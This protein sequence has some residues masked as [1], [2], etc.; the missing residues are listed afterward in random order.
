MTTETKPRC[1]DAVMKPYHETDTCAI[2]GHMCL[3]ESG[4]ECQIYE[5]FLAKCDAEADIVFHNSLK[6]GES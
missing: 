3:L 1:P 6:E 2:R 5:D 4:T